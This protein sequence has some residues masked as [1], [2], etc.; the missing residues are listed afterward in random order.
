MNVIDTRLSGISWKK[1]IKLKQKLVYFN[2]KLS[3][4]RRHI[5]EFS[6]AKIIVV[7]EA[8]N[9][10]YLD[11]FPAHIPEDLIELPFESIFVEYRPP[12]NVKIGGEDKEDKIIAVWI[13]RGKSISFFDQSSHDAIAAMFIFEDFGDYKLWFP[14]KQMPPIQPYFTSEYICSDSVDICP[15]EK[16]PLNFLMLQPV[17]EKRNQTFRE[18]VKL[19][20]SSA[21]DGKIPQDEFGLSIFT[22]ALN[23]VYCPPELRKRFKIESWR[24]TRSC[25]LLQNAARIYGLLIKTLIFFNS[26]NVEI[27]PAGGYKHVK[28][29]E[30]PIP[31]PYYTCRVTFPSR[32]Y[33]QGEPKPT[34]K[35]LRF[36]FDVRGHFRFL[37]SP[38]FV[39]KR[40]QSIWIASHRRGQGIYIPKTYLFSDKTRADQQQ[41]APSRREG[42]S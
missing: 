36:R 13:H 39:H 24:K 25:R 26:K 11:K 4:I 17:L 35:R 27:I 38:R 32:K 42:G 33:E 8:G 9:D 12:V 16:R 21:R 28:L 31:F 22:R 5:P 14:T 19:V 23:C 2:P 6:L 20:H 10:L 1:Q 37:R 40:L 29:N 18:F 30:S 7:R 34:E 3:G 15:V 41:S